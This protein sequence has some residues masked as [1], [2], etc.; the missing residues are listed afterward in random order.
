MKYLFLTIVI[1]LMA[2]EGKLSKEQR[3]KLHDKMESEE[4]KR[5]T[6]A[7]LLEA[8]FNR[9]RMLSALLEKRDPALENPSFI[10][11]L[12]QAFHSK[13]LFLMP[14]V[15]TSATVEKQIIDAYVDGTGKVDLV[16]D[17]QKI[18]SDSMLYTKPILHTRPDGTLEFTKALG[19]RM[20]KKYIVLSI[21]D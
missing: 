12:Q 1:L 9:G 3:R 7:Q 20:S 5:V 17:V 18:G 10:D 16:D 2:C 4:L 11:S 14:D 15:S 19:I 13:I 8:A 6:D 21:K